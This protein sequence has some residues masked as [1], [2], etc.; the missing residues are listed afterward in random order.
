MLRY[1]SAPILAI[2]FGFAYPLFYRNRH[3]PLHIYAFAVN[4]MVMVVI[5]VG[6]V[7]PRFLDTFFVPFARRGEGDWPYAPQVVLGSGGTE[8]G[9]EA[10]TDGSGKMKEEHSSDEMRDTETIEEGSSTGK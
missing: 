1:I 8:D 7:F 3:D 6:F 5:A 10:G 4:H 9:M 2:V